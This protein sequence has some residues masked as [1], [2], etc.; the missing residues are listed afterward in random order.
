[1]LYSQLAFCVL[2]Y[3]YYNAETKENKKITF[4]IG[5]MILISCKNLK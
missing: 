2:G 4:L 1:M 3:S 5:D